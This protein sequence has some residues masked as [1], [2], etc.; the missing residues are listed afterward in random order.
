M[1]TGKV[2]EIADEGSNDQGVVTFEVRVSIDVAD[3]GLRPGMSAAAT[4]VTE[5]AKDALLVPN[6]AVKSNSDGS[7]YVEILADGETTPTQVTVE[8]GLTNATQTQ[9]LSG[10]SEGDLVVTTTTSSDASSSDSSTDER[11]PTEP[12]GGVMGGV[13]G[14]TPARG[15]Q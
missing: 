12:G 14:G 15:F 11:G 1:A 9:I 6:G 2:Y 8:T 10:L 13:M 7:Y 3:E 4:I 5:I